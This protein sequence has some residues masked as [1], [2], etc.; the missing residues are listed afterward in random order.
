[1]RTCIILS[2]LLC[3]VRAMAERSDYIRPYP[4]N[5][6]YW[7]YKGEPVLLLGG[8]KDDSPFQIPDLEPYLDELQAAGMNCVRN[9]MSDRKDHGFEV[10]PFKQLPDGRYDLDQWNEE[11]WS[12][13]ANCLKWCEERDIIV[14]I[15]V[16]DRFD[17]SKEQWQA[18]PWRPNNNIN[19][20]VVSSGLKNDYPQPAHRDE[21][22]FFHSVEGMPLYTE[23]LVAVRKYQERM[24]DKMLSIALKHP[25]VLFCM[26]NE[27]STPVAW[28][29]GWM[30]RITDAARKAG[31]TVYVTDMFNDGYEPHRSAKVQHAIATPDLYT[32][33]DL[34]QVNSR[35]FNE[36]H[37]NRF[38]YAIK[39]LE[40]N[41]RPLNLT[42]IYSD[43]E[44][45]WGSGTPKDGVER[46]WRSLIG[47]AAMCRFHRDGAGLGSNDI[48]KACIAA[49]RKLETHIKLWDIAPHMELLADRD[50][51]EAY[52]AAK[53]GTA[54][55]LYF[56]DG[57]E[58]TLD[59]SQHK[60]DFVLKWINICTGEYGGEDTLNGGMPVSITVPGE[61]G[62]VA[63]ITRD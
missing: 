46:F 62:W 57:G 1:M 61:G 39:R 40:E 28:G 21:Q 47:G 38:I 42:K 4:D 45:N 41:P 53:P 19:Y 49:A 48:A 9:T 7:Q 55:A 3:S 11:Y 63:V 34:S 12:R 54:Y 20:T 8:S 10:Y 26:D 6:R 58:V 35:V 25:N 31:T 2:L 50:T 36:E 24:V 27:T 15:E 60:G 52:L 5:P 51:D 16:W 33:I 37:W 44:T 30:K 13:F 29:E 56:T 23:E 17:Y 43:G 32:F 18:S 22:P 14:Q 59:L